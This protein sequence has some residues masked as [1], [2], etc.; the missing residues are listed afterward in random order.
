MR[1]SLQDILDNKEYNGISKVYHMY[2]L[3]E[4]DHILPPQLKYAIL[5]MK[6]EN[7]DQIK[8][9]DYSNEYF[10]HGMYNKP[11]V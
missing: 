7:I 11:I 8:D 5:Q 6:D 2:K 4:E 9:L 3:L 1:T 10:D